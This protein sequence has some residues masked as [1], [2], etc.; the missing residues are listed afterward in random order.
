MPAATATLLDDCAVNIDEW[1]AGEVETVFAEQEGTAF[2]T[3]DGDKKPTGFLSYT[4][5]A[6][7]VLGLGEDRLHRDRRR[8]RL[9]GAI[10]RPTSW[11]TS[12]MR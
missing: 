12:S 3:G 5:V 9:A 8:R 7:A 10:P 2:V 11:S 4:T 1:L 6:E